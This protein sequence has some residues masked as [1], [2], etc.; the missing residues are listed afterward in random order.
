MLVCFAKRC[1][2]F[3]FRAFNEGMQPSLLTYWEPEEHCY[4]F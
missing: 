3:T 2:K 4:R 1:M